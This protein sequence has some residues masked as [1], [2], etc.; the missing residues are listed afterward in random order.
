MYVL[1]NVL[2]QTEHLPAILEGFAK[3]GVPGTTVLDSIGMGRILMEAS[4]E[5]PAIGVIREV[6]GEG[7][8]TNRT[9]FAVIKD[10]QTVDKAIGVIK[11]FCGDLGE[12]GKGILFAFPV[13]YVDG[14]A[15]VQ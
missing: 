8:P 9:I 5:V 2:E 1:V 3:I 6:L 14:I 12:P 4:A 11:S 15:G 10:K 7:K 13:E